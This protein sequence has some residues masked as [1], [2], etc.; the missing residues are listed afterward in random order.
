MHTY[1]IAEAGVNH[2]GSIDI[3]RQLIDAAAD[4]K[5]NAVKFQTFRADDLVSSN[6]PKAEYQMRTTDVSETQHEMLRK[7]ELTP[8]AHEALIAHASSRGIEFLSTPFDSHSLNMLVQRFGMKIVKVPSGEITNGPFL[9]EIAK[10][11]E[12]VILS[13]GMSTLAEVEQALGWLAYG[14]ITQRGA[15][16]SPEVITD[17]YAATAGQTA[18]R[19]RVSLLHCTTEYPAPFHEVNL[20][21][22]KTM[23]VAFGLPVGYSDHTT[24]VHIP[25]AAVALGA[26][27]IEKHFTLNREMPGP[28]HKASLEPNE[29]KA[30]VAAI[31][32]VEKS[33]GDGIKIPTESEFRNRLMARKSLVV[34][35]DTAAGEALE[36]VCKRPGSGYSPAEYWTHAGRPARR[37]Y[38]AG[39]LLD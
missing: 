17:A 7:L 22:M 38:V 32:E 10:S 13:T 16:P 18:L 6:A 1:I 33:L 21:A 2:N 15:L 39:E 36:L 35:R 19:N 12:R 34:A 37:S 25:V 14:F 23:A 4:A 31:R 11:A 9:I 24:G 3:A 5:V 28:D 29:L 20:K 8:E 27:I 30:M 26:R